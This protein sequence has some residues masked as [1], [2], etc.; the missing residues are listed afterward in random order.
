MVKYHILFGLIFFTFTLS[1]AQSD[2]KK[3]SYYSQLA[4]LTNETDSAI[5]YLEKAVKQV[6]QPM[7]TELKILAVKYAV[8]GEKRK[9]YQTAEQL[10]K[11]GSSSEDMTDFMGNDSMFANYKT[12]KRWQKIFS[13]PSEI[14]DFEF[15]SNFSMYLGEDQ[16]LRTYE[17]NA[18]CFRANSN[19]IDSL[20]NERLKE[21]INT[22]GFPTPKRVGKYMYLAAILLI[23]IV[24]TESSEKDWGRYYKPLML[25]EAELGHIDYQFIAGLDDRH[26]WLFH[27]TQSYGT[28]YSFGLP[29]EEMPTLL[30]TA[31]LDKRRA[32]MGLPPFYIEAKHRKLKLPEGYI[33][34]KS[35]Y[36]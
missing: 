17:K 3:Y 13:Q 9:M 29:E 23:H 7:Y 24:S 34:I 31:N 28:L 6:E 35:E 26:N 36:K 2:Y 21:Y 12:E 1:F 4:Y 18:D 10:R 8:K 19:L 14:T 20:N 16:F 27:N 11:L 30:D 15:I 32:E 33:P 5:Y 22:Y 25:K